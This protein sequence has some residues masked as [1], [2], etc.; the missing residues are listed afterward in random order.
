MNAVLERNLNRYL[1][2]I[3]A[4]CLCVGYV[5]LNSLSFRLGLKLMALL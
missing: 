3:E 5:D 1:I 4:L 2:W